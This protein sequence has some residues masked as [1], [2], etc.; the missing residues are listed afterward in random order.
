VD[1]PHVVVLVDH[2]PRDPAVLEAVRARAAHG[3]ARFS[4]L[5]TNP[6]SS[7]AHLRH[8]LHPER[9]DGVR[10]VAARLGD[11]TAALTDAAGEEVLGDASI[12]HDPFDALE[13]QMLVHR[14]DEVIVSVARHAVAARLHLDLVHRL[15][16]RGLTVIEVPAEA[17][18]R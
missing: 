6:R 17:A 12:R 2:D 18:P 11:W 15:A 8:P 16:Q 9:H 10:A 14:V 7:E 5:V 3:P 1:R 13:E 4:L